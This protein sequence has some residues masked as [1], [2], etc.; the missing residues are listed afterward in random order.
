MGT[1][2]GSPDPSAPAGATAQ[3]PGGR[4]WPTFKRLLLG[5]MLPYWP[6]GVVAILAMLTLAGTQTS[7]VALIRPLLDEGIAEQDAAT[8]RYYALLLLGFIVFQGVVHFTANYLMTWIGRQLV[9]RLRL[10]VHDRLLAMPNRVFDQYT[11]GRLISSLTYEVEQVADVVTRAVLSLVRDTARVVF[12]LGYMAYLSPWLT[13]I[14]LGIL[15]LVGGI[16]AYITKRFRKISKRIHRAVGGVGSVAEESVHGYQVI[17]AFGQADR[18]R[19]RFERVNEQNRRQFMKFLATKYASVPLVRLIAGLALA[20][21]IYLVTVEALVE[22][23]TIGTFVSFA[24]AL[25]L[26]NSPLRSLVSINATIQKGLAAAQGVFQVIDAPQEQDG[27]TR[28]LARAEG[29]LAMHGLRFAYDGQRE[30]LRGIDLV[31]RPGET[32]ALVGP[33]GG[34][35]TTLVKLLPRFYEPTAGEIRLDG[36]PLADY[37]LADLRRQIAMV[38]QEVML[39]SGSVADNIR[40]G[41]REPVSDEQIRE[42]AAAANALEFIEALP[43]GFE[44][45]V[46]EDGV[47]LSGGQRQRIAIARAVLKDAPILIL[48]EATSALDAESERRI[49]S[50]LEHLLRDRTGLI[51]AHRLSTVKGADRIVFLD[52]G[53]IVEQGT[54]SELLAYNGRYAGLY[55]MQFADHAAG[56]AER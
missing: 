46:G 25:L 45:H 34:G 1:P 41:A 2:A 35:K 51:I 32:L 39:L 53:E 18:E 26:L 47:L 22:A 43:H 6:A 23:I 44:T 12:L 17:K 14:V 54:H 28:A 13:L 10:D 30:V 24:S 38:G 36:V 21:V 37:R 49:Q 56:E 19:A 9:K 20:L 50:A 42:A 5:Y 4:T 7:V 3:P 55:R 40:Y 27:G 16:I 52:Q 15:P 8:V 48:D 31:V 29:R 33:S 11:P